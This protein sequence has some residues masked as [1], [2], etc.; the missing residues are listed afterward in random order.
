MPQRDGFPTNNYK[1]KCY[2]S[3]YENK[4]NKLLQEECSEEERTKGYDFA[5]YYLAEYRNQ[6]H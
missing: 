3:I 1:S 2:F 5:D 4:F 6:L